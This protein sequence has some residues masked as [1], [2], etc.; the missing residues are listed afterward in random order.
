MSNRNFCL[1]TPSDN[2]P[3]F[4]TRVT[5]GVHLKFNS[6]GLT[7]WKGVWTFP[8]HAGGPS[9]PI[10]IVWWRYINIIIWQVS[11]CETTACIVSLIVG[12]NA[13]PN[14]LPDIW[15]NFECIIATI[16]SFAE[17]W[18]PALACRLDVS[19][20]IEPVVWFPVAEVLAYPVWIKVLA[21]RLDS[22]EEHTILLI[23]FTGNFC[24]QSSCPA[25]I[26]VTPRSCEWI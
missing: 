4:T 3:V 24:P 11:A 10:L 15:S 9:A 20:F 25:W 1:F 26:F 2:R 22:L 23:I 18:T 7:C 12:S 5:L 19:P 14:L 17:I 8:F 16:S 6:F 21:Q 13:N